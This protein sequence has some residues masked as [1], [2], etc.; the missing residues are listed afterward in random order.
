MENAQGR[1]EN[2]THLVTVC[3]WLILYPLQTSMFGVCVWGACYIVIEEM[4]NAEQIH[5]CNK[6]L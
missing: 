4:P 6:L 1:N 2:T 3:L 5:V